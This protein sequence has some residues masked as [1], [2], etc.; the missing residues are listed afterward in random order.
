MYK[1]T[2]FNSIFTSFF[3]HFANITF[4]S[5]IILKTKY[6]FFIHE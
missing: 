3:I 1:R 2:V 4:I 6:F 5:E